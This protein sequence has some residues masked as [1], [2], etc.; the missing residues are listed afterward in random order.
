MTTPNRLTEFYGPPTS[1]RPGGNRPMADLSR[2]EI[3]ALFGW[4]S[5]SDPLGH[6]LLNCQ[7]F[8]DLVDR[9]CRA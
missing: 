4:Q 7:D 8:I 9:A 3:I 6:T 5:F 1:S 2:E